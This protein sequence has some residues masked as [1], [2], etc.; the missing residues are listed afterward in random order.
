MIYGAGMHHKS[1]KIL[2]DAYTNF[3]CAALVD[4]LPGVWFKVM[5]GVHQGAPLSMPLY[6]IFLNDLLVALR[7]SKVGICIGQ[8]DTTSP[9][10]ADDLAIV[11]HYKIALNVL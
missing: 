1:W 9:A 11:A 3:E 2:N 10:H 4:G 5:R 8:I 6:Q 7:D